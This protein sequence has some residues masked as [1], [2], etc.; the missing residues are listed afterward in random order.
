MG[1]RGRRFEC[2][3]DEAISKSVQVSWYGDARFAHILVVEAQ[4][5]LCCE[6]QSVLR[7]QALREYR[8]CGIVEVE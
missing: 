6:V 5:I 7:L 3:S 8:H 4:Y 2:C 1:F